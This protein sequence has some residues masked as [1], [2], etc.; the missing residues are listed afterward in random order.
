MKYWLMAI[1]LLSGFVVEASAQKIVIIVHQDV[2]DSALTEDDIQDIYLGKKTKWSDNSEI[3]PVQLKND[4]VNETFLKTFVNRSKRLYQNHWNKMVFTGQGFPPK[5]FDSQ[6]EL[7][8][9]VAH[10]PGAISYI[11]VAHVPI[12]IKTLKVQN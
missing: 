11:N 4:A 9:Y 10:T 6:R 8:E 5:S 12:A 7:I 2:T 1:L 3:K